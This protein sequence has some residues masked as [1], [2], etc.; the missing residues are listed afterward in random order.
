MEY[1]L[2]KEET[3]PTWVTLSSARPV[4][5]TQGLHKSFGGHVV[6]NGVSVELRR[7]EVVLLRGD[8]G[9]GKTT[10]LNALTGN[11]EPDSGV[12]ELSAGSRNECFSFPRK[13]WQDL[14]PF[15]H[16]TPELVAR[17]GVGRTWQDIRLFTTQDL[18][19][20]IAV[21]TPDQLGENPVWSALRAREVRRRERENLSAA[22]SM[23][24]EV[25]LEGRGSSFA[26]RI[27]LGQSRRVSIIRAVQAGAKILFLDEPMA[28]L[29]ARGV[30]QVMGLLA[31]LSRERQVTMVIVEHVSHIHHLLD[32]VS[33][34]W[35]LKS[36]K[37]SVQEPEEVKEE[38]RQDD[39]HDLERRLA[40]LAGVDGRVVE[41][42]LPGGARLSTVV[43]GRERGQ[44]VFEV[45]GLVVRRGNRL[46][47]GEADGDQVKG[48]SLSLREGE[49]SVLQAPN[50]W[51]KTTLLETLAGLLT[52]SE[53]TVKIFGEP[54][55]SLPPWDRARRGLA[56]LQSR[57]HIFPSLTA[58]E[59]LHLAGIRRGHEELSSLLD[60]KMSSLSGGERQRVVLKSVLGSEGVR[61]GILDEP[62][63]MLDRQALGQLEETLK[64]KTNASLLLAI[65]SGAVVSQ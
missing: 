31:R 55:E 42:Q 16:F 30:E 1:A 43:P 6:L 3:R 58:K 11:L 53:G 48:L 23:L 24:R 64:S 47:V 25:G 63:S 18:H 20:N 37:L 59:T 13:W 4:L 44:V 45:E 33:T 57:N 41:Q 7:G 46:V 38:L 15:D 22:G 10:L 29:D 49:L 9:S 32:F 8:N 39:S 40:R 51:G 19:N 2:V 26:D 34:V 60:R 12:V 27:S 14:N 5:R 35:T 21:A 56:F 52:A 65:P 50:G 36:G 61:M 28:G 17:R 54:I 62:F